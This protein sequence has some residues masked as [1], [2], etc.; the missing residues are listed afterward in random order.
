MK[1]TAFHLT[2]LVVFAMIPLKVFGG[3][4]VLVSPEGKKYALVIGNN[5]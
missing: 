4:L 3:E 2:V 5:N 1:K